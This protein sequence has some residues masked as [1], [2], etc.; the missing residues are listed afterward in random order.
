MLTCKNLTFDSNDVLP[1]YNTY[2]FHNEMFI[3]K[4]VSQIHESNGSAAGVAGG[5][6][7]AVALVIIGAVLGILVFRRMR[8]LV[9]IT[10]YKYVHTYN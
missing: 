10:I 3:L 5:V 1:N 6:G 4:S 2:L 8:Q 7:A 9:L